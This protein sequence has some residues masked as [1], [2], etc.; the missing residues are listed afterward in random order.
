MS[1]Q[2]NPRVI[3][4]PPERPAWVRRINE[5]GGC[6]NISAVVPLDENS[7]LES[8]RRAT[9]LS[10][11][12]DDDWREPFQIYVDS[13]EREADFNLMGRLRTR[14]EIL[15]LL[16]ARLKIEDT[17]RRH[18]EIEDEQITQPIII[19]GQG[20]TGTSYLHNILWANPEYGALTYWEAM[21]PCPPP[22][23]STYR[24][25]P[26]IEK[27]HKLITQYNRVT[28]TMTSMHEFAGHLPQECTAIMAINF[29]APTWLDCLGQAPTYQAYIA[30]Q[31]ME[32]AFRYHRRV[33]KL[34]QWKNPR[35]HWVLKDVKNLDYLDTIM[36]VYPDACITWP[37]RDPVR[38]L[39]STISILGTIQW[40][41]TDHPFKG[42]SYE[43][44]TDVDLSAA[45]LDAVIDKLE[46][47]VV[48]LNQVYHLHYRDLVT[49][50]MATVEAL[51][52]HFGI[53]L[54]DKG[55]AGMAKYIAEHPRDSRP[56]HQ[57]SIGPPDAVASA[58]TAYQR[59]QDYFG[60][61]S[62]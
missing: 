47:G 26:R 39:A 38:A 57:F 49:D 53:P 46:A 9:G 42:G 31:D 59:Y 35:K 44:V 34:L 54:S 60:I 29:M 6:M 16:E 7:L 32:P 30:K 5:E 11:F 33:L 62:E 23:K 14:S 55:R 51:H 1:E 20:R 24:T 36:K 40:A 43:Y 22:E 27:A 21:F 48:P 28:P 3:W 19:V 12:G 8:A 18:P 41:R 10:D 17:Y 61:V 50:P 58:R 45:R 15:Y 52:R 2:K 13:L 37:H 25:D 56:A 4:E